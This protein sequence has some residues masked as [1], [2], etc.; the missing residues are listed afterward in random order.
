MSSNRV[1]YLD[2]FISSARE[3]ARDEELRKQ[4]TSEPLVSSNSSRSKS[5]LN[6][7]AASSSIDYGESLNVQDIA[8]L[9]GEQG[10]V[11]KGRKKS[12]AWRKL[13]REK[14]VQRQ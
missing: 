5:L 8:E 6:S 7:Q 12:K 10:T 11:M 14:S 1:R 9:E 3:D 13:D 2:H 4:L